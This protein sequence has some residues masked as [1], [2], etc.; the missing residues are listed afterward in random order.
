MHASVLTCQV[1]REVATALCQH[2]SA[3]AYEHEHEHEHEHELS[4]LLNRQELQP[5]KD[6]TRTAH[7]ST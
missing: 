4:R 7:R 3:N 6:R 2:L 5:I 1:S